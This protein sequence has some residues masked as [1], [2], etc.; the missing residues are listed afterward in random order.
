MIDIFI[1]TACASTQRSLTHPDTH[2]N[3][4][5]IHSPMHS[6]THADTETCHMYTVYHSSPTLSPSLAISLH[7]PLLTNALPCLTHIHT[8][9]HASIHTH[10]HACQQKHTPAHI[11]THTPP[12]S[13]L[14]S[15]PCPVL[16]LLMILTGAQDN[17]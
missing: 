13:L 8:G 1:C 9:L 4:S 15:F 3:I 16:T 6:S 2:S 5:P 14:V 17:V 12:Q 10:T 11:H 7:R